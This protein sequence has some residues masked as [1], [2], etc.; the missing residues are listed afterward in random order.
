LDKGGKGK[1]KSG[2]WGEGG[3]IELERFEQG[4]G[5]R[6]DL[7]VTP[8]NTNKQTKIKHYHPWLPYMIQTNSLYSRQTNVKLRYKNHDN[9]SNIIL[10]KYCSI[11]V[12]V[13]TA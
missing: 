12:R 3:G 10:A 6:G 8:R 13:F 9:L 11:F 5:G 4:K 7:L 1:L 2:G